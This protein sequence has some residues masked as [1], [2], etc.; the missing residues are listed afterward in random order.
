MR[1]HRYVLIPQLGKFILGVSFILLG[2][3]IALHQRAD[4]SVYE[5]S[6]VEGEAVIE[7]MAQTGY[8]DTPQTYAQEANE[9]LK[10]ENVKT[11]LILQTDERW[12]GEPYGNDGAQNIYENG[13][14]IASLAMI[15]SYFQQREINP[16]DI[17]SWAGETY[18]R[19]GEGT[20][21]SIF[22]AFAKEQGYVC[23][24]LKNDFTQAQA[25]LKKGIPVVVS[26][27]AGEFTE[28]GHIMVLARMENEMITVLDPA[29]DN[30]KSHSYT[31]YSPDELQDQIVNYWA[32]TDA[33]A[34]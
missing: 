26:V 12:S 1:H 22:P 29:D 5:S 25:Y 14:A 9:Y 31:S 13:C 23:H 15:H 10:N 8:W 6:Y 30:D 16:L 32:F 18:Y 33:P 7:N 24:D 28:R 27:T 20:A 34:L 17:T 21:W 2:L 19:Q 11:P 4:W 3:G